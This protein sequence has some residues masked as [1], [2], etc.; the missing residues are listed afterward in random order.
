MNPYCAKRVCAT[1]SLPSYSRDSLGAHST[2][3]LERTMIWK[4]LGLQRKLDSLF[5][6]GWVSLGLSHSRGTSPCANLAASAE[7]MR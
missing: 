5:D 6:D 1:V 2:T 3:S 4:F 7:L